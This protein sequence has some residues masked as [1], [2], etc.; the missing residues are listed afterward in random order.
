MASQLTLF[1]ESTVNTKSTWRTYT[2]ES[3]LSVVA[4]PRY[5]LFTQRLIASELQR[6]NIDDLYDSILVSCTRAT[7]KALR[8]W[9]MVNFCLHY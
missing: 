6:Y 9:G 8:F 5:E 3:K 7:K 1:R 2:R 4:V